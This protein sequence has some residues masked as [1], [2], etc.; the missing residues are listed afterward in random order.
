M[1][2]QFLSVPYWSGNGIGIQLAKK[3]LHP[4]EE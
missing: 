2:L 4:K 3:N 1:D